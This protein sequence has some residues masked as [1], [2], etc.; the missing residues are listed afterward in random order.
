MDLSKVKLREILE[1]CSLREKAIVSLMY[2]SGMTARDI[3]GLK[4]FDFLSSVTKYCL[5]SDISPDNLGDICLNLRGR[6]DIIGEWD[7]S[8]NNGNFTYM[9]FCPVDCMHS[10]MDWLY[11]LKG[12][13]SINIDEQLFHD[14]NGKRITIE[15]IDL[16]FGRLSDESG[17]M[18][19]SIDLR[20]LFVEK[21][22]SA[23]VLYDNIML[24]LGFEFNPKVLDTYTMDRCELKRD[25]ISATMDLRIVRPMEC[26]MVDEHLISLDEARTGI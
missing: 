7:M 8:N 11:L 2:S 25:Y 18:I 12:S 3:C 13:E 10:I 19:Q 14:F 23:G 15:E 17:I 21:M 26:L 4:Y 9:T 22:I 20:R 24:Y 1:F 6:D 5:E 16:I